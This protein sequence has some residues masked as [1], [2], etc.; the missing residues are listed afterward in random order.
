M[1][2]KTGCKTI[3]RAGIARAGGLFK[4][5]AGLSVVQGRSRMKSG[6]MP[7]SAMAR[8]GLRRRKSRSPRNQRGAETGGVAAENVGVQRVADHQHALVGHAG[9]DAA[10]GPCRRSPETACRRTPAR[11]RWHWPGG[12]H[13]GPVRATSRFHRCHQIRIADQ[14]LARTAL[15]TPVRTAPGGARSMPMRRASGSLRRCRIG[16]SASSSRKRAP[17][18]NFLA[19]V[20]RLKPS[21]PI[22]GPG[23]VSSP[24]SKRHAARDR[25][26]GSEARSQALL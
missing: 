2:V 1:C 8:M 7:D 12:G 24:A 3:E 26:I 16:G 6:R 15:S 13:N 19:A 23:G 10:R 22:C 17:S 5:K 20:L 9:A 4:G 25:V 21:R 14:H 11:C 18:G